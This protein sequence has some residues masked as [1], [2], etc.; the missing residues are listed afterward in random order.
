[1]P[2]NLLKHYK[3]VWRQTFNLIFISVQLSEMHGTGNV[4]R[5][6]KLLSPL[7]LLEIAGFMMLLAEIEV[8]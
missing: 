2:Q 8:N 1:M 5:I 4:E 3:E 7:Q 6:N